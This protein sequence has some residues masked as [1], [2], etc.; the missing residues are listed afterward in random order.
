MFPK[1]YDFTAF[2]IYADEGNVVRISRVDPSKHA[3][4]SCRRPAEYLLRSS[5][6]VHG[7][8]D[9]AECQSCLS[10][11]LLQSVDGMGIDKFV[12]Q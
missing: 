9:V 12:L 5:W 10:N 6:D 3:C 11:A 8:C 7:Q 4:E 1:R 2:K